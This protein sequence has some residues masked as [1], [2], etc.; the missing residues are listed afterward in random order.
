MT[1]VCSIC[2][3]K[4]G[5]GKTTTAANLGGILAA[6]GQRVLGIDGDIQPGFSSYYSLEY[7]APGGLTEL[8]TERD[9]A[10][11]WVDVI[12]STSI[13]GLDMVVS[14]DSS[15]EL[16]RWMES[17]PDGRIRL[18]RAVKE[19]EGYDIVLIDS[20]GTRSPLL[21][22]AILAGDFILS[23]IQPSKLSAQ[24]FARGMVEAV[25]DV[26][27]IFRDGNV[28]PLYGMVNAVERNGDSRAFIDALKEAS[29]QRSKG[30]IRILDTQIPQ[31]AVYKHAATA[32]LPV[33]Q[34]E[35]TRKG[36][37]NSAAATMLSL[38]HELFEHL[39]N[40]ELESAS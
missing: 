7:T 25:E 3:T 21:H 29:F 26:D 36:P 18:R 16:Q 12:S 22:S 10:K 28:G 19:L 17:T 35:P 39:S 1:I 13:D 32:Q 24:E 4:G 5:T 20:P 15:G 37:T 9:A 31:L 14:N 23:P 27:G 6:L 34:V 33:H 40:S 30:R 11:R 38:V 8:I 2:S